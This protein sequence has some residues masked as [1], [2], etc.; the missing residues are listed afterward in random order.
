MSSSS[1]LG[2]VFSVVLGWG[3]RIDRSN[4]SDA[5]CR[6]VHGSCPV[7]VSDESP[8]DDSQAHHRRCDTN[9]RFETRLAHDPSVDR[10]TLTRDFAA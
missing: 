9:R 10:V 3:L 8:S 4:R 7:V 2:G 1:S 6:L 5:L